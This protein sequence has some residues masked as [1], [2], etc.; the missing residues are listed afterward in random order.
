MVSY[1]TN[2]SLHT[3][4][5]KGIKTVP[6]RVQGYCFGAPWHQG[7]YFQPFFVRKQYP[8]ADGAP[9]QYPQGYQITDSQ[10]V[11][12]GALFSYP[13]FLSVRNNVGLRVNVS[14]HARNCPF[15]RSE[16]AQTLKLCFH[17]S[18]C[19]YYQTKVVGCQVQGQGSSDAANTMYLLLS[20]IP[21]QEADAKRSVQT[22]L[23]CLTQ[24]SF[25]NPVLT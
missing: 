17:C 5:Q 22:T 21:L 6:L 15:E 18:F 25:H 16:K 2:L 19:A 24:W 23:K 9:K 14:F 13:F 3:Q 10:I 1:R 11:P 8:C 7:Y 4:N 12:L 20:T